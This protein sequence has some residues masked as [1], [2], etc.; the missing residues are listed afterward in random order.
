MNPDWRIFFFVIYSELSI[1]L[2]TGEGC[3]VAFF[4]YNHGHLLWL[5]EFRV[6]EEAACSVAVWVASPW[7]STAPSLVIIA[8]YES[9]VWLTKH[10]KTKQYDTESCPWGSIP[11]LLSGRQIK[12]G[13]PDG[14]QVWRRWGKRDCT[15]C[16]R[17]RADTAEE[18]VIPLI[19][20]N[21]HPHLAGRLTSSGVK[22]AEALHCGATAREG[23]GEAIGAGDTVER[24][25][26]LL[27]SFPGTTWADLHRLAPPPAAKRA[28]PLC[29]RCKGTHASWSFSVTPARL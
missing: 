24:P 19:L 29:W 26:P 1:F 13:S 14:T 6:F 25:F 20:K 18:K 22:T 5:F 7:G 15:A 9:F 21:I 16:R 11:K 17:W 10:N 8:R 3:G 28:Q 4:R 2:N 27:S 23:R 12:S